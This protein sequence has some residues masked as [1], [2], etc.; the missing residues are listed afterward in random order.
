MM[1]NKTIRS[2][3]YFFDKIAKFILL[4][5]YTFPLYVGAYFYLKIG[6]S[7]YVVLGTFI[8]S[9]TVLSIPFFIF[10]QKVA[11]VIAFVLV[12]FSPLEVM[13]FF[14]YKEPLGRG[15]VLLLM[16]TDYHEVLELIQSYFVF[17][18]LFVFILFTYL[19]LLI[20]FIQNKYLFHQKTRKF[21]LVILLVFTAV[22]Y[23]YSFK[24]AYVP[25]L[26]LKNNVSNANQS[27]VKKFRK[28]YPVNIPYAYNQAKDFYAEITS[29]NP[30]IDKFS[31]NAFK[32]DR[33]EEREIYVLVIGESAR[34]ASFS[35]NGYERET[36]P[37]L[38]KIDSIL[39]YSNVYTQSN[40]TA[41]SV[42]IL[43]TRANAQDLSPIA[44]EKTF[45]DAFL[46]TGFSVYWLAN[47]F[48]TSPY[49]QSVAKRLT[50]SY[51]TIKDFDSIENYDENLWPF[52]EEVLSKN[53]NKQLIVLHTLGSHFRYN[54]RY[55][56]E[57]SHFKP[58]LEGLTDYTV[59]GKG[60]KEELV[61]SYDN[62]IL[63]TDY[64][65]SKTIEKLNNQNAVSY[66]FYISDHGENL[67]DDNDYGFHGST[68]PQPM[69][70][71]VPMIIWTSE[72]YRQTYSDKLKIMWK[73]KDKKLS[74]ELLFYSVLEMANIHIPNDYFEKSILNPQLKNES[75][76]YVINSEKKLK[77]FEEDVE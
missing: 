39:S 71:H 31:F 77:A 42:P 60:M 4:I 35:I 13:H 32:N 48:A 2:K 51:F 69:E 43:L 38:S 44:N 19:F 46:E 17:A 12:L 50:K 70:V 66:L 34:Y 5:I 33:L 7:F 11:F 29:L 9:V 10:K 62:T 74:S 37:N 26:Q 36:N 67:Y 68:D 59:L 52:F 30:E 1:N 41:I 15:F 40:N 45:L 22:L 23:A 61:N 73:N 65:L 3:S 72:K 63:Y 57:F 20:R 14:L 76:R 21:S 58:D 53:E 75:I 8:L 18:I 54:T 27:F 55:P 56:E 49:M 24:G 64:F 6:T 47:Q 25:R 28:I 16:Q